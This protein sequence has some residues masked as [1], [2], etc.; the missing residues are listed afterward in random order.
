MFVLSISTPPRFPGR[1]RG[2]LGNQIVITIEVS[3]PWCMAKVAD[4]ILGGWR[5]VAVVYKL[6]SGETNMVWPHLFW[7]NV[8]SVFSASDVV[9]T[10]SGD[11]NAERQNMHLEV[12]GTSFVHYASVE[13]HMRQRVLG[14]VANLCSCMFEGKQ[15]SRCRQCML[16][17]KPS[18]W[19]WG[20]RL[21]LDVNHIELYATPL[22]ADAAMRQSP[23]RCDDHQ[24]G[25]GVLRTSYM[26]CL[27]FIHNRYCFHS[28]DIPSPCPRPWIAYLMFDPMFF[29]WPSR[30]K[31][32]M[33]PSTSSTQFFRHLWLQCLSGSSCTAVSEADLLSSNCVLVN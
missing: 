28:C 17:A 24:K 26:R 12:R 19:I 16:P 21:G 29:Y 13:R 32:P 9:I 27:L 22:D 8:V 33:L 3:T 11:V 14:K 15:H 30:V 31:R 25:K 10:I 7:T 2:C 1:F 23:T 5:S 6:I 20:A 18:L 4:L